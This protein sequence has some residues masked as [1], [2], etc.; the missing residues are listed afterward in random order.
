MAARVLY[1][2]PSGIIGGAE[3]SLLGLVAALDRE[4]FEPMV[5]GPDG[6]PLASVVESLGVPFLS[7]HLPREVERLSLRGA[8]SSFPDALE[9]VPGAL[10]LYKAVSSGVRE[11]RLDIIHT[12]GT[13]A[14][15][16]GAM[17]G[18]RQQ[19]PVIWHIR[20]FVENRVWERS[21]AALGRAAAVHIIAN[22]SA[23]AASVEALGLASRMEVI[24][25]GVD[26]KEF[27]PEVDGGGLRKEL[28]IPPEAC[29]VGMVGLFASWKG[30]QEFLRSAAVLHDRCPGLLF[31]LVGDEVYRTDGHGA[32]RE[33]LI[34]QARDHGLGEVV[35]FTGYRH[36][37]PKVMA[38][39]D[40]VI[41]ASIRPEP[42]GRVVLEA[43]A[44]G[45]PVVATN[46]GGVPEVLGTDGG[47]G[48]LV[49][50]GDV[51]ALTNAIMRLVRDETLRRS[52]GAAGRQRAEALF[53]IRF[54]A[55]RVAALYERVLA[56]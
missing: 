43:M 15:V 48:L 50:P 9:A 41:H 38:A 32:F 44:M 22:S 37:V 30:Q 25:N 49:P 24:P 46:A 8:R 13:K 53:D 3:R 27:S 14:H 40:V 5:C 35:T 34:R 10:S 19:V 42:F 54:H 29:L 52:M 23:V 56:A 21:I 16:I 1:L 2:I 55:A 11:L 31:L 6:G 26:L 45:R 39:L 20:D 17:A 47:A 33:T 28:G 36:D 4:R 18:W 7:L 12:N 51:S